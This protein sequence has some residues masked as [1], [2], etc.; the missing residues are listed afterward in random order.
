MEWNPSARFIDI[1]FTR[2]VHLLQCTER[3]TRRKRKKD[4]RTKDIKEMLV[5]K[6]PIRLIPFSVFAIFHAAIHVRSAMLFSER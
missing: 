1:K 2:N 4:E 6:K 3:R 5:K